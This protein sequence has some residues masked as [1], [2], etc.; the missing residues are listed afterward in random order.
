MGID[1]DLALCMIVQDPALRKTGGISM[2]RAEG[3]GFEGTFQQDPRMRWVQRARLVDAC[4]D[5]SLTMPT[6]PRIRCQ[7]ESPFLHRLF[8]FF[9]FFPF[10]FVCRF[11]LRSGKECLPSDVTSSR[12]VSLLSL[13]LDLY[14]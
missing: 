1:D 9:F 11:E 4:V 13:P 5:V 10:F 8:N 12:V 3:R 6:V 7:I 2:T 14:L